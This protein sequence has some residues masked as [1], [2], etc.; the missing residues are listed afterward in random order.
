MKAQKICKTPGETTEDREIYWVRV[1]ERA[2]NYPAGITV[3]CRVFKIRK[4]NY[5]QWFK[6]LKLKHPEWEKPLARKVKKTA[7]PGFIPVIVKVAPEVTSPP[8]QSK[9]P[10]ED[11]RIEIRLVAGHSIFLPTDGGKQALQMVLDALDE[12]K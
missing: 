10:T 5:Y 3:F 6:R 12:K 11:E 2:R 4:N 9:I 1:I 8:A 7:E